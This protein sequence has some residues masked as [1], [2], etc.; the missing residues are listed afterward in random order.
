MQKG[1]SWSG[2]WVTLAP[3]CLHV[4]EQGNETASLD[5]MNKQAHNMPGHAQ[6]RQGKQDEQASGMR[7][8]RHEVE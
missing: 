5:S 4:R 3:A 1:Q 8:N 6:A 7:L 2:S